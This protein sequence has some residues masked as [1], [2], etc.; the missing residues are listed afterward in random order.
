[1]VPTSS[2]LSTC[3]L[4]RSEDPNELTDLAAKMPDVLHS[5]KTRYLE[6][7][8]TA[9]DQVTP[10]CKAGVPSPDHP[11][12]T[13]RPCPAQTPF[14]HEVGTKYIAAVRRYRGFQGPFWGEGAE[15]A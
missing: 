6:L 11:A 3:L 7:R 12:G 10:M 4:A 14:T 8:A 9:Y 2:M 5:L 1:M 15:E 13:A